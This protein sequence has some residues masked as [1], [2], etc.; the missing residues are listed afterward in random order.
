MRTRTAIDQGTIMSAMRQET[1]RNLSNT[2]LSLP[3]SVR[4]DILKT[5][6]TKLVNSGY[7][8]ITIKRL[9]VEGIVK[10]EHL[11]WRDKLPKTHEK[12]H[13]LHMDAGF[14]KHERKLKK[15]LADSNWYLPDISKDH[16]WRNNV[17]H[18]FRIKPTYAL[19]RRGLQTPTSVMKVPSSR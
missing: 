12:Y 9:M 19:K 8:K 10:F 2:S 14:N 16:S 15:F 4:L 1:V 5:F 11:R 18:N 17:P 6:A 7:D 3:N 13:P